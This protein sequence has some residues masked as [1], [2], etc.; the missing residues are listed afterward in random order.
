M[1]LQNG[2]TITPDT[3]KKWSQIVTATKLLRQLPLVFFLF[4]YLVNEKTT[5]NLKTYF[6]RL[7]TY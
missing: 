7:K 6:Y 2:L 3:K 5:R 4:F 1:Y